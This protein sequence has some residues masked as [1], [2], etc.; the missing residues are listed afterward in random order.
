MTMATHRHILCPHCD[1]LNRLPIDKPP[2]DGRCGSCHKRL[3][4]GRPLA[5]NPV[6]FARYVAMDTIPL[7]VDVWAS[8][9]AP[10]RMMA[11]MFEGAAKVL[12][13]NLR[14]LKLNADAAP[15]IVNRYGIRGIPTLLLFDHGRLIAQQAGAMDRTGIVQWARSRLASTP[16]S[17]D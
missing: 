16:M 7:L 17:V 12:E 10:C 2:L 3:F 6:V 8:W 13:P 4:E 14:L 5:V 15:E 11:P 9:C 1:T